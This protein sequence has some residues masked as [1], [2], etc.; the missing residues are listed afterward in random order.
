MN[1]DLYFKRLSYLGR[2][3]CV[4]RK[5]SG[6]GRINFCFGYPYNNCE[7]ILKQRVRD[8]IHS[9]LTKS[10]EGRRWLRVHPV[11]LNE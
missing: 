6:K 10:V 11:F 5:K 3:V 7:F 1:V 9:F 2:F 8:S 4:N